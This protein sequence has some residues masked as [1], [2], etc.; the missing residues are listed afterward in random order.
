MMSV[1]VKKDVVI[2]IRIDSDLKETSK[3]I[4]IQHDMDH[5][6]IVRKLM[7]HIEKT[8]NI[9]EFLLDNPAQ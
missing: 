3:Q 6:K 2:N 1:K 8:G 4:L 7:K 9:P 5:S